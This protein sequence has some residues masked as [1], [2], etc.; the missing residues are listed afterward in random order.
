VPFEHP[1]VRVIVDSMF[2]DGLLHPLAVQGAAVSIPEWA[3][4]GI[5]Q[6]P[7]ALRNLVA[8]GIKGILQSLP[9]LESSYRDW[10]NLSRRFGEV[11]ARFHALDTVRAEGLKPPLQSCKPPPTSVCGNG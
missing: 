4:V 11:L 9:T 3:K 10:A 6:D 1:D 2:L 5:V 7:L 8:E